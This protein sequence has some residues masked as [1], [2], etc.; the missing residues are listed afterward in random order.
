MKNRGKAS[1]LGA[2]LIFHRRAPL[3]H[4]LIFVGAHLRNAPKFPQVRTL[5]RVEVLQALC[6]EGAAISLSL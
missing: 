3:L 5:S 2:H 4:T 6:F 1:F